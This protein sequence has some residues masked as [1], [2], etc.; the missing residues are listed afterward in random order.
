MN[1]DLDQIIAEYRNS[2]SASN[3]HWPER[4]PVNF[5]D[6]E[7]IRN[8]LIAL[9]GLEV[10]SRGRRFLM[11]DHTLDKIDK[12]SRWILCSDKRGL[13]L[14]GSLGNGKSTMLSSLHRLFG[15]Y[16]S[17]LSDAQNLF[18]F[19]KQTQGTLGIKDEKLLLIDDIGIEPPR[20]L[21]YG[22]EYYPITRLL[23]H[24]YDKRLTTIV[25]TNLDMEDLATRYGDRVADRMFET[26][27]LVLYNGASYRR[28]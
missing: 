1:K 24:R 9:N 2:Y 17:T 22:E 25:A 11:D 23:L 7:E 16:K 10:E 21:F 3:K 4:L 13:I 27:D 19:Y 8:R 15:A 5:K 14:M 28:Q 12:V 26:Y 20:C 18:D 6:E